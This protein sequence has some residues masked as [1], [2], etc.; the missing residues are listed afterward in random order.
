MNDSNKESLEYP[1]GV[2][3]EPGTVTTIQPGV[4]WVRTAMPMALDHINLYLLRHGDGWVAVES[5]KRLQDWPPADFA[6]L[7]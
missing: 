4:L 5:G 7:S 3:Q 6:R 1:W 2:K